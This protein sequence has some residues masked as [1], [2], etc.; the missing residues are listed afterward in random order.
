MGCRRVVVHRE[1]VVVK[2]WEWGRVGGCVR[3]E[4]VGVTVLRD[5]CRSVYLHLPAGR[6]A[7]VGG[8]GST[9]AG[10]RARVGVG[11]CGRGCVCGCVW[12]TWLW[13]RRCW[14]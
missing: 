12:V 11:V 6:P 7:H 14:V 5:V 10:V 3:C 9:G 4:R 13:R 8:G 1:S 2:G